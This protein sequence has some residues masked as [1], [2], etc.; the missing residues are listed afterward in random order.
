MLRVSGEGTLIQHRVL[1]AV[2]LCTLAVVTEV[3]ASF[4]Q[5]GIRPVQ[6][7]LHRGKVGLEPAELRPL[8]LDGVAFC[9]DLCPVGLCVRLQGG[10]LLPLPRN[11]FS[12]ALDI[13][14][15]VVLLPLN[16]VSPVLQFPGL[17]L[18]PCDVVCETA[19]IT[20]QRSLGRQRHLILH[21]RVPRTSSAAMRSECL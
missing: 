10:N 6:V 2:H 14:L 20:L 12:A 13:S 3:G 21:A 7:A 5:L 4:F 17:V 15:H 18:L 9:V 11:L 19:N 1:F 16:P 8:K